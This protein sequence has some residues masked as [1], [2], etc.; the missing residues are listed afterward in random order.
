MSVNTESL[1]IELFEKAKQRDEFEFC[2][3]LLKFRGIEPIGWD[4]MIE[5]REM[6]DQLLS[7]VQA[8]I[9]Q[10]FRLRLLLFAYCHATEMS[11]T[12]DTVAN[13]LRIILG[14]RWSLT[15]FSGALHSSNKTLTKPEPKTMRIQEWA[16][17]AG[18]PDIGEV[19]RKML[20]KNVRNA[21]YHSD[22]ILESNE[23]RIDQGSGVSVN[24][25]ITR[26]VPL[27]WLLE[28]IEIAIN[29]SISVI[30][31]MIKYTQSYQKEK[32]IK[33]RCG[34]DGGWRDVK[35]IVELGYGLIG[36]NVGG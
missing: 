24:G 19:M 7:L 1:L 27:K 23:F 2:C 36:F 5:S 35:L 17:Q 33:G 6:L 16:I 20:V 10:K 12:Y 31:L 14:E 4:A 21:V 9:D 28:N 29:F 22:Y 25:T 26:A 13:L 34:A 3:T 11:V 32:V 15:P 30:D 8:P 18:M